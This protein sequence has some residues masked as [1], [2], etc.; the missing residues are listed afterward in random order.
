ME[1]TGFF[2]KLNV[3][4]AKKFNTLDQSVSPAVKINNYINTAA[5]VVLLLAPKLNALMATL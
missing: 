4:V 3:P 2:S 1:E 5:A